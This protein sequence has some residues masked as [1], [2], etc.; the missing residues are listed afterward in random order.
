MLSTETPTN[1]T[2]LP[3]PASASPLYKGYAVHLV[4]RGQRWTALIELPHG[5]H[6]TGVVR[7]TR[8]DAIDD[9]HREIDR[10]EAQKI[11]PAAMPGSVAMSDA[12]AEGK[13]G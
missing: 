11:D 5:D 4:P 12:I 7:D 3:Q 2:K 8:E 6:Y 1:I 13:I 9:A 10:I